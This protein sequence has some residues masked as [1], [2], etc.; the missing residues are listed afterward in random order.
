MNI[1]KLLGAAIKVA[2]ANP[3]LVISAV[4]AIGPVVKAVKAEIK[5]PKA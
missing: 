1:G 3:T 5:K 4:S 2:K